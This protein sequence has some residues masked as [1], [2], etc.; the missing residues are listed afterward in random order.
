MIGVFLDL[1]KAFDTVKHKILFKR[2][3]HY[4]IRGYLI[5]WF[6]NY[7]AGRSHYVLYNGNIFY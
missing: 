1:K 7:L 3:Y 5:Q 4:G 2:L 6:V